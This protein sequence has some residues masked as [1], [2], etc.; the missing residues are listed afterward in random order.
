MDYNWLCGNINQALEI[1]FDIFDQLIEN[2]DALIIDVREKDELPYVTEFSHQ[3]IPLS[4]LEKNA[5]QFERNTIIFFCQAGS[6]SLQAAQLFSEKNGKFKNIYS[7]QGGILN[8]KKNS[9]RI[10]HE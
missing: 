3:N 4:M 1:N 6:R 10:S 8:W 5:V 7:L 2:G 9:K